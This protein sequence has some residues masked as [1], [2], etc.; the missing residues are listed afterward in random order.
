M[1]LYDL[2]VY[3]FVVSYLNLTDHLFTT[4]VWSYYMLF[5]NLLNGLNFRLCVFCKFMF[6]VIIRFMYVIIVINTSMKLDNLLSYFY[7]N[8]Y[9]E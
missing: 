4:V 7:N 5:L 3:G 8:F 6:C 9:I 1:D 2:R